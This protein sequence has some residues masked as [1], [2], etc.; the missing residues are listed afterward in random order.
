MTAKLTDPTLDSPRAVMAHLIYQRVMCGIS[1]ARV[2]QETNVT[3]P[4]I[5]MVEK[6][7]R[8]LQLEM[9]L[10]YAKAV[11]LKLVFVQADDPNPPRSRGINPEWLAQEL[12]R[13]VNTIRTGRA[14]GI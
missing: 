9:V 5:T 12:E 14:N 10:A 13:L 4:Y 7:Q 3:A 8:R 11:G 1:Q 2:A 6:G